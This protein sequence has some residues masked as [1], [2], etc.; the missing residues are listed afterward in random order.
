MDLH[1]MKARVVI[2][3][4]SVDDA[5][6]AEQA[7]KALGIKNVRM[8]LGVVLCAPCAGGNHGAHNLASAPCDCQRCT[9]NG[10]QGGRD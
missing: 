3:Y 6:R 8:E 2:D 10:P 9:N 4:R 5:W 7:F 1:D